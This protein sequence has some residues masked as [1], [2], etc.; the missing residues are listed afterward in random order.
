[1]SLQRSCKSELKHKLLVLMEIKI[2]S[3]F[4]LFSLEVTA[5][6]F[7]II[8]QNNISTV[9][10]CQASQKP[11]LTGNMYSMVLPI[12]LPLLTLPLSQKMGAR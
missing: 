12:L 11:H 10:S 9:T 2:Q 3:L 1:M 6:V 8:S 7:S 5:N 4:L